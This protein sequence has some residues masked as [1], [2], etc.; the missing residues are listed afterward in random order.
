M[1]ILGGG[2]GGAGGGACAEPSRRSCHAHRQEQPPSVP[3][4]ALP[5]RDRRA[6]GPRS[7]RRRYA[8]FSG[9]SA[10]GNRAH[11]RR[12]AHRDRDAAR[13]RSRAAAPRLRLSDPRHRH[14]VTRTSATSEWA[15]FAPGLKTVGDALDVRRRILRAFESAE[16]EPSPDVRR[17]CTT[18]VVI[19]GGPT[20]VELAGALAEIAGRTLARDFRRFDPRTTRVILVEA[21]SSPPADASRRRCRSRRARQLEPLGIEVRTGTRGHRPR[22]T[23]TSRLATR[24]IATRTVLWAAGVRASPLATHLGVAL[25]QRRAR[26]GPGRPLAF[27]TVRRPSWSATSSP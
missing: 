2:F 3:A 11:G 6:R 9:D 27:P 17:A 5:G 10:N 23:V 26:V 24:R 12:P 8:S 22:A 13:P 25:D 20:G 21:G 19:G 14:D 4:A 16:L 1:I 7:S 15:A 18:F